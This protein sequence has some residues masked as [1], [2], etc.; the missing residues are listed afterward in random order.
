MDCSAIFE[1]TKERNSDFD[2]TIA[3]IKQTVSSISNDMV[4]VKDSLNKKA[5]Q[6]LSDCFKCM[7]C[8][9]ANPHA[10]FSCPFCGIF[11]GCFSCSEKLEKCPI[12]KKRLYMQCVHGKST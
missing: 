11:I 5:F 3:E 1:A 8:F 9:A 2:E 7:I 10:F 12:C 6:E 4:S